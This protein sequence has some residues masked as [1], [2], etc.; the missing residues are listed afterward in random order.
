MEIRISE[1]AKRQLKNIYD[2]FSENS[3]NYAEY[4]LE[5]FYKNI[6]SLKEFP[7]MYAIV[8]QLETHKIRKILFR[9]YRILYQIDEENEEL[10]KIVAILHSKQKL[11]I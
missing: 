8:P 2:F 5:E 1:K 7:K 6:D 9:N 4:F 11:Q 10:I 3:V